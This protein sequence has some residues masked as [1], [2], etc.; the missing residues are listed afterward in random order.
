M[1]YPKIAKIHAAAVFTLQHT[2][3][4]CLMYVNYS[5]ITLHVRVYRRVKIIDNFPPN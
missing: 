2:Q 4:V 3:S 5:T 1:S